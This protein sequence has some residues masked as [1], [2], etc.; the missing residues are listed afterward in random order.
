MLRPGGR[1]KSGPSRVTRR[2]RW[3][4]GWRKRPNCTPVEVDDELEEFIRS[5][6]D[7]SAHGGKIRLHIGSALDIAP[8]LGGEF[9]LVFIDGDKREY[10]AHYR[11]LM[12]RRRQ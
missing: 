11:M 9:D 8:K 5:Y 2:S 7:R 4:R 12:G 1:S 10:P 6:F 3:P